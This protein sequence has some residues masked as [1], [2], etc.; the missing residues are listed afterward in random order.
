M[1]LR[2]V[3]LGCLRRFGTSAP[4]S[5]DQNTDAMRHQTPFT[6]SKGPG[7]RGSARKRFATIIMSLL[8]LTLGSLSTA[9]GQSGTTYS[10]TKCEWVWGP[11]VV[12]VLNQPFLFGDTDAQLILKVWYGIEGCTTETYEKLCYM[13][14]QYEYTV[15]HC[16]SIPP[17]F[18][19]N[20]KP[21]KIFKGFEPKYRRV[22]VQS[23]YVEVSVVMTQFCAAAMVD[24]PNMQSLFATSNTATM[25][26]ESYFVLTHED[27][28]PVLFDGASF[29]PGTEID[30]SDLEPGLHTL[31]Y[32]R[33]AGS[34]PQ[35]YTL[36]LDVVESFPMRQ[37]DSDPGASTFPSAVF[38]FTNR[39]PEAL[40]VTFALTEID[41]SVSAFMA[42]NTAH[43]EAGETIQ[44]M[45]EF[46]TLPDYALA[47]GTLARARVDVHPVGTHNGPIA[48]TVVQTASH[49]IMRGTGEDFVIESLVPSQ[50]LPRLTSKI[51]TVGAALTL[52]IDSPGGYFIGAP[53]SL[54]I[55]Q[56]DLADGIDRA[57]NMLPEYHLSTSAMPLAPLMPLPTGGTTVNVTLDPRL[58]GTVVRV[59]GLA[60]SANANN[61]VAALTDAH[62]I[63]VN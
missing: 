27:T 49:A 32:T 41:P 26:V 50:R 23:S 31:S 45:V 8:L 22:N 18:I 1:K 34:A 10:E 14:P 37:I 39:G 61:G 17:L 54:H 63:Y 25:T 56:Y 19:P 28:E 40:D 11:E 15:A 12:G 6:T 36:N 58:A 60:M 30:L 24:F 5:S 20:V 51:S 48:S 43:V 16:P 3:T 7:E 9:S 4:T 46:T 57:G 52:T 33:M 55:D 21:V 59:Q 62:D 47:D 29:A 13:A 44:R 38:E 42:E 2:V 35:L 53:A